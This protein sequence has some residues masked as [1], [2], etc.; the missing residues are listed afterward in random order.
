MIIAAALNVTQI[1][2]G[3]INSAEQSILNFA[4]GTF[5][6]EGLVYRATPSA[7]AIAKAKMLEDGVD[8]T[9]TEAD[10]YRAQA[11]N[12]I[13]K[14]IDEG[15]LVRVP[16]QEQVSTADGTDSESAT[17]DQG[18]LIYKPGKKNGK[19]DE[20]DAKYEIK[21]R[22]EL[23]SMAGKRLDL[24]EQSNEILWVEDGFLI[25]KGDKPIK[26]T[27]YTTKNLSVLLYGGFSVFAMSCI[28]YLLL[29][30]QELNIE[31]N[32]KG[33]KNEY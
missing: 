29:G 16:G 11:L 18:K 15:F 5:E 23:Q 20:K 24:S 4:S 26:N 6:H 8:L 7:I 32:N 14:G 31:K 33:D 2:A 27:G 25:M 22:D 12:N 9:Q 17:D 10:N 30:K 3:D 21:Y 13:Q 28:A 1:Y 19:E